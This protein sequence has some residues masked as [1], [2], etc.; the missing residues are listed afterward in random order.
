[1]RRQFE[2]AFTYAEFT[3]FLLTFMP[4]MASS[5]VLHAH[6]PVPRATGRWFRRF[7]RVTSALTPLWDFRVD[8]LP[9]EDIRECAGEPARAYVVVSNHLSNADAFLL[10]W[11][12][13]D[14]QW[15]GKEELFRLPLLGIL[16]RLAGDIP[17]KRGSADSVRAMFSECRHALKHGLSIMLF[18]EGTRSKD[19][20]VAPFKEGAFQLAI[21]EGAPILPVAIAGTQRCMAKNTMRLGKARAI[22]RILEPIETRGMGEAD[23]DAL[24]ERVERR[25]RAAA[26]EL[27]AELMG[28]SAAAVAAE[29][30][31][32]P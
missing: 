13:W 18:P 32:V 10:S 19:G 21:E 1:M 4:I 27:E 24:R 28:R 30:A 6:D 20:G 25:I 26:A 3:T 14:M 23:V 2:N 29:W 31:A 9:P 15:V 12:P 11:L 22:A 5:R 8:G 16:F 17:L 7:G